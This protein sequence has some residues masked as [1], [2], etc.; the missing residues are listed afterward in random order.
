MN[1]NRRVSG[2][3]YT[4]AS[5]PKVQTILPLEKIKIYKVGGQEYKEGRAEV[6]RN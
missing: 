5:V 3:I 4:S 6:E 1:E 2:K